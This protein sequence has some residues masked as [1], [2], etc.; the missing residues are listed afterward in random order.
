MQ[1]QFDRPP[2]LLSVVGVQPHGSIL[3]AIPVA[4][5]QHCLLDRARSGDM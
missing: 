1:I 3:I 4:A 5:T 2:L